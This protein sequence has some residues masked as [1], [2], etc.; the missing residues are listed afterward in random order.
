V[1]QLALWFTRAGLPMVHD[2]TDIERKRWLAHF[3]QFVTFDY[4][5]CKDLCKAYATIN[6]AVLVF[7]VT[8]AEKIG[9]L[10]TR[11]RLVSAAM[12]SAWILLLIS[13]LT[14]GLGLRRMFSGAWIA[15]RNAMVDGSLDHVEGIESLSGH[16][17]VAKRYW[18]VSLC[19][20]A[21]GIVLL[22]AIGAFRVLQP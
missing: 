3:G 11:S 5:E 4:S 1:Y 17:R 9:G 18:R 21:S 12:L 14:C 6:V 22:T 8:F 19:C 20:F 10:P 13:L 7:S 2:S 15:S 16:V